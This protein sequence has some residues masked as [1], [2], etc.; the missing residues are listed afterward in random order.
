MSIPGLVEK[1]WGHIAAASKTMACKHPGKGELWA[2][3]RVER[4]GPHPVHSLHIRAGADADGEDM[5]VC[6]FYSVKD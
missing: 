4:E 1:S 3:G 5:A 2:K 6:P